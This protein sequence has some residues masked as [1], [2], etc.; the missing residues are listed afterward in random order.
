MARILIVEDEPLIAMMLSDWLEELG[1]EPI[2]ASTI[3]EA[4]ARIDVIDAAI[5]D[6]NLRGR[7][8]DPV[9]SALVERSLPF[10]F[11]TG[12]HAASVGDEYKDRLLIS[13]PYDFAVFADAVEKLLTSA[14]AH[15]TRQDLEVVAA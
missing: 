5:V 1:H 8:C 12:D 10:A 7:R 4:I 11:S 6:L 3:D 2:H 15:H 14:V 13:K 9:A